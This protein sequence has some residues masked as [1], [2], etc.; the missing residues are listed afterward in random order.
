MGHEDS[1][2]AKRLNGENA[3]IRDLKLSINISGASLMQN[4]FLEEVERIL[5]K[6]PVDTEAVQFE[7]TESTYILNITRISKSATE[8]S[9]SWYTN[10]IR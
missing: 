6:Y 8:N 3:G 2:L 7:I 5:E 10:R 4:S 1:V 9:R